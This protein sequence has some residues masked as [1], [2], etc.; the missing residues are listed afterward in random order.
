MDLLKSLPLEH[1]ESQPTDWAEEAVRADFPILATH[2]NGQQLVYLDSASTT[3]K[4]Q[5]VIDALVAYYWSSNANVHRGI[6]RLSLEATRHFDAARLKVMS[7]LNAREAGEIVFVRGSTEGINLVADSFGRHRV[8]PGDEILVSAMEHHANIVP[9]QVFCERQGAKLQ[10]APIDDQGELIW[11]ELNRLITDRTKLVAVVHVSNTLGTINPI[12]KIVDL[13]HQRGAVVLVD[14]AQAAPHLKIDVQSLGCDFY[15]ISG[16]KVYGPTGI[17]ALYGKRALLEAMPPYQT[18][19]DMIRSV[20]WDRTTYN[21]P[22]QKFEAGTPDIAGA[23]GLGAAIDYL[24]KFPVEAIAGHEH[25]LLVRATDGLSSI[26]GLRIV[27]QA[28]DKAAV[29]SFVLDG[30]HPHDIGTVLDQRGIAV[31]SGHHCTQPLM[32]RLGVPGTTRMSFGLYNTR[33]E[34]DAAVRAVA[35]VKE[36]FRC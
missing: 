1:A 12:R 21:S 7:F 35:E 3:Q 30:V 4:P 27:G 10:V 2:Y 13:A 14:G 6:Y 29:L 15:V 31:R 23:I 36:L 24:R 26:P 19:G 20:S 32:D 5:S 17:G 11:D 18:G 22:P 25:D 16:H 34:V 9:W 33:A 8:G 28:A